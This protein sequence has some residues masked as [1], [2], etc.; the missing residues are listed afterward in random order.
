[1][2]K[3][4]QRFVAVSAVATIALLSIAAQTALASSTVVKKVSAT[5]SGAG[6]IPKV[7]TPATGRIAVTLDQKT[8]KICWTLTA[9]GITAAVSTDIHKAPTGKT[10][11]SVVPLG[12]KYTKKGCV[13]SPIKIV[14]GIIS[15]PAAYYVNIHTKKFPE[16]LIAGRLHR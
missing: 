14:K 3:Q 7:G 16:G 8:G 13:I 5:L 11:R 6:E 15:N 9:K 2:C 12:G 4:Y 1:M 10:G